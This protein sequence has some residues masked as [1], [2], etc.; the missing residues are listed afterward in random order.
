MTD[1]LTS[2][3]LFY[4]RRHFGRGR[5][6]PDND[7]RL[8]GTSASRDRR[9]ASNRACDDRRG[10]AAGHLLLE[11]CAPRCEA[12]TGQVVGGQHGQWDV[13]ISLL[14]PG[15]TI[16]ADDVAL[17]RDLSRLARLLNAIDVAMHLR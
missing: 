1:D 15:I 10:R 17:H 6:Y 7:D 11:L 16:E 8:A 5:R 9:R 13:A 2:D 4:G 3:R 12:Y 14:E